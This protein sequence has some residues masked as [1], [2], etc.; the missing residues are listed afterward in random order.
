MAVE[1][2]AGAVEAACARCFPRSAGYSTS[3]VRLVGL[4]DGVRV[5]IRKGAFVAVV[6]A[7]ALV[8][9]SD[10]QERRA[11]RLVAAARH[12]PPAPALAP[13]A[14]P[15]AIAAAVLA[16]LA[17]AAALATASGLWGYFRL[18]LLMSF[19]IMMTPAIAWLSA[20]HRDA[21]EAPGPWP[22]LPPAED[23]D[24]WRA[25]LARVDD[26]QALVAAD[27]GHPFRRG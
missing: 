7:Q 14:R 8:E 12:D 1:A 10:R 4:V 24:R 25:L 19:L 11:I 5:S 16:L 26:P 15:A 13:L 22:A 27:R 23:L 18:S 9:G 3:R 20:V 17:L 2:L 6:S 21:A